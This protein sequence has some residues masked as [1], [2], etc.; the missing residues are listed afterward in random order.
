MIEGHVVA[1]CGGV[2]GAKLA[3]GLA[4]E[5]AGAALDIV[6][7]TG[8]DFT[9]LGLA[10]SPDIDTVVYTLSGLADRVRGWGVADESWQAMGMLGRLGEADW[11]RLGD[12][13][14]AMHVARTR[15]LAGGE[16]LS[17]VTADIAARLGIAPAIVPMSD[18]AVRTEI[19]TDGGVLPF[20]HYFVA[21]RCVPVARAIRFAGAEHA[22][23]SA[24]F[25]AA[26]GRDDLAALILCPSNPYLSV[27][28]ILALPGMREAIAALPAARIAVSPIVGGQAIKGPTAK[29]M[30][31]LGAEA[32]VVGIARHYRGLIDGILIDRADAALTPAI[33]AMG[34]VV[35][36]GDIVMRSDADRA[37]VAR[38]TLD[39]AQRIGA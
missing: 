25:R 23:P 4:A 2:G 19:V 5:L 27:D 10:I 39:L 17:A 38:A 35:A 31:E 15:R 13:D 33:E 14:L 12:R 1:L 16:T 21:E 9:H 37:A 26:L 3:F 8:D 7:N 18:A 22:A 6:V 32:S 28:P 20:Q 11:F 34:L 36:T 30:A 29:L 24:R